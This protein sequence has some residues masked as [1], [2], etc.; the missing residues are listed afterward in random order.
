MKT[1][2]LQTLITRY[3]FDEGTL[4]KELFP[5][6]KFAKNALT[7]VLSGVSYLDTWQ[8]CKLSEITGLEIS[9]LFANDSWNKSISGNIIKFRRN[10]HRVEL[11][12]DTNMTEIFLSDKLIAIETIISDRSIKLSEYL[13]LVDETII[14]LI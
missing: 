3:N 1:F 10:N 8:L 7:R 6:N 5:K 4:A 12:M 11:N 9:E 13:R 2:D 14:N